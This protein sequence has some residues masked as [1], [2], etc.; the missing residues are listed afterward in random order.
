M[1]ADPPEFEFRETILKFKKRNKI[2]SS[3]VY[4]LIEH[5]IRYFHVVV[6]QKRQRNV[7]KSVKHLQSCCFAY[8]TYC[9]LDVLVAVASL[10]LKVPYCQRRLFIR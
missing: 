9:F 3:L 10:N 1:Y 8:E 4:V 5:G 2:S 7:Q 6:V